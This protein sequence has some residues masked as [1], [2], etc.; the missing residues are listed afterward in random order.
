MIRTSIA[1]DGAKTWEKPAKM[2]QQTPDHPRRRHGRSPARI[3]PALRGRRPRGRHRDH[4]NRHLPCPG[5]RDVAEAEHRF[6]ALSAHARGSGGTCTCTNCG[7]TPPPSSSRQASIR[8]G[9]HPPR[10]RR[11]L[12]D[13]ARLLGVCVRGRRESCRSRPYGLDDRPGLNAPLKDLRLQVW[14][15]ALHLV[16][17]QVSLPSSITP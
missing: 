5:P 13:V 17:T 11:R 16:A 7:T 3:P 15:V 12:D 14:T 6:A 8:G 10:T 2:H 9:R 1:Q 4:D